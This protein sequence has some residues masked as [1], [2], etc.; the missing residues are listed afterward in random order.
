M[1]NPGSALAVAPTER[2]DQQSPRVPAADYTVDMLQRTTD[3]PIWPDR[4]DYRVV[5]RIARDM[6][7]QYIASLFG[8]A[9]R[10]LAQRLTGNAPLDRGSAVIGHRARQVRYSIGRFFRRLAD[11]VYRLE[12]K[13][14]EAYLA[15]AT[16]IYDLERRM[17]ELEHPA[18]LSWR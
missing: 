10:A 13:R 18:R 4:V 14:R 3:A 8:K 9:K 6:R 16:D 5:E 17:R 12:R 1:K 15:G 2:F 7:N 11:Y